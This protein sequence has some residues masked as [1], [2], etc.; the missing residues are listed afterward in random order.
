VVV[1]ALLYANM[2]EE[3]AAVTNSVDWLMKVQFPFQLLFFFCVKVCRHSQ[4]P[5]LLFLFLFTCWR[6]F[7]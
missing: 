2:N 1:I 6:T 7:Q 4:G 5:E 3:I